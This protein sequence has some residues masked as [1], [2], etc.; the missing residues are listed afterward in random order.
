MRHRVTTKKLGRDAEHRR[1][2]LFNLSKSLIEGT[3]VVTT[4]E[5]A[6]YVRPHLEKLVTRAKK[7]PSLANRRLLLSNLRNKGDLVNKLFDDISKKYEK[8][9]G[10]YLSIKR[11]SKRDGDKATLAKI[12]WVEDQEVKTETAKKSVK[13]K[14][15]VSAPKKKSSTKKTETTK[16]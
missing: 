11:M 12:S 15:Q 2:L 3:S 5:K 7:G 4:I 14:A 16:K 1:A 6:K 10:G 8:R 9:S 13:E